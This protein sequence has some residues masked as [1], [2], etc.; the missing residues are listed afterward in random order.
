MMN[1]LQNSTKIEKPFKVTKG[2]LRWLEKSFELGYS[3]TISKIAEKVGLNRDNWYQW[4][5]KDGFVEWWDSQ[6]DKYLKINRWKLDAIG[7]KKAEESYRFW[8]DMMNRTGNI[9]PEPTN[10]GAQINTQLNIQDDYWKRIT[11]RG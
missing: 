11:K 6:W 7:L 9:I 1:T 5:N 2:M 3:A 4:A 10:I 8:K